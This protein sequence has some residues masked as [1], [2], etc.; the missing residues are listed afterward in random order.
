MVY[1]LQPWPV[2]DWPQRF[3]VPG[4]LACRS[5]ERCLKASWTRFLKCS[6][7]GHRSSQRRWQLCCTSM[8]SD[9]SKG[10]ELS[11]QRFSRLEESAR[12]VPRSGVIRRRLARCL[13][14][15]AHLRECCASPAATRPNRCLTGSPLKTRIWR[16][17][18]Y[19][20]RDALALTS[21][22]LPSLAEMVIF[23]WAAVSG[24]RWKVSV[25]LLWWSPPVR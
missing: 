9:L 21:A 14:S 1:E 8:G 18:Y 15:S 16:S 23:A 24:P 20:R 13:C 4:G 7:C 22:W 3:I 2:F 5:R 25:S 17:V 11:Y 6:D 12:R 19:R 10:V